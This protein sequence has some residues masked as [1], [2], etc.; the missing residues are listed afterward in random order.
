MRN[1]KHLVVAAKVFWTHCRM[2]RARQDRTTAEKLKLLDSYKTFSFLSQHEAAEQLGIT[3]GFLQG[4]I[5]NEAVI[6]ATFAAAE[7]SASGMKCKRSGKDANIIIQI[8]YAL[9]K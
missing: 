1:L 9:N 8:F 3:K 4:L 6:C 7:P 5:K 2:K